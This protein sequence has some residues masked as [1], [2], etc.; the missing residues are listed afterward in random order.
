MPIQ[1][2]VDPE[3]RVVISCG[4][5]VVSDTDLLV[6]HRLLE[7]NPHFD[8]AF[9][10]IWDLAGVT[11][12]DMSDEVLR[13]FAEHSLS[14][15]TVRRAAVCVAPAVMKRVLAFIAASRAFKRDVVLFPPRGEALAWL[16]V[17]SS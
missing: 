9:D 10:R 16:A 17:G 11:R 8:P 5:G 2:T 13:R 3:H 4:W 12:L 7:T 15:S 1:L 6:G 14:D